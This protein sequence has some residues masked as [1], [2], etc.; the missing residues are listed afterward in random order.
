M[1]A[2]LVLLGL[3]VVV[4]SSSAAAPAAPVTGSTLDAIRARG[5]LVCGVNTGLA[6]FAALTAVLYV[7]VAR[8][9][10]GLSPAL[11]IEVPVA[12]ER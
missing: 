10:R 9:S 12:G 1:R 11:D 4:A 5:T 8:L 6:G 2:A 7:W 3:V